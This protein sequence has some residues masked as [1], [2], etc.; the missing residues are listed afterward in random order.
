MNWR[1]TAGKSGLIK[2]LMQDHG[3]SKRKA[4]K[5]VNA[6]FDLMAKAVQR[7][8]IVELPIGWIHAA[9]PPAKSKRQRLQKF[10]NIQTGKLAYKHVTYPDKIIRFRAH[11]G[12]IVRG[13]EPPLPPPP[14]S[15]EMIQKGEE[16]EQLLS[17]LGFPDVA[18]WDL[19]PLLVAA[20]GN[21]DWLL[22]RLRLLVQEERQ[23]T[24][25]LVLCDTVHQVYWIRA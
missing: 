24:S 2:M 5:A 15:S 21:L 16:L 19:R 3:V 10:R 23:F 6:V 20:Q 4:E 22:S 7:G 13:P 8:D 17:R 18:G 1:S 9:A 11:P 25:F 14:P 12:M